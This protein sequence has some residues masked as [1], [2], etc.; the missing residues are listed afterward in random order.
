[1]THHDLL[2]RLQTLLESGDTTAAEP[3]ARAYL[4]V[5]APDDAARILSTPTLNTKT[6][7]TL[8]ALLGWC[9]PCVL[10]PPGTFWMGLGNPD[11]PPRSTQIPHPFWLCETP[12]T[13]AQWRAV[14]CNNPSKHVGVPE[15]PV[16]QVSWFESVAY[17]NALSARLCLLPA[18]NITD[19][20][21]GDPGTLSSPSPKS[22]SRWRS[23]FQAKVS[24]YGWDSP[25]VRLPT[26]AEW[27]YAAS[28]AGA[29][30]PQACDQNLW[31]REVVA[32]RGPRPAVCETPGN[33]FGLHDTLGVVC[34][35]CWP[36]PPNRLRASSRPLRGG[37]FLSLS[38][39][40]SEPP[41]PQRAFHLPPT[42]CS[43]Q[44]GF[45]FAV[46]A[47]GMGS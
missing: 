44:T 2:Q 36:H 41:S 15:R 19:I 47:S 45:R 40:L 34:E 42:E 1:M 3:L 12:V 21:G 38:L 25:A 4:R 32:W 24:L 22:L 13:Q 14:M 17:C 7:L 37:K 35:W 10:I 33:G 20:Q 5:N 29:I 9:P 11:I 18:Y 28:D 30:T 39:A 26:E 6:R 27:E 16:E 46:T 31:L 23:P 8:G 43:D